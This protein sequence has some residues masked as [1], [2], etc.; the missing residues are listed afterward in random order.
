MLHADSAVRRTQQ[1]AGSQPQAGQACR[2]YCTLHSG[3][4]FR[5]A[6]GSNLGSTFS[7]SEACSSEKAKK[8]QNKSC[9]GLWGGGDV[10]GEPGPLS[11]TP[12][13]IPQTHTGSWG[14]P[15]HLSA[16]SPTGPQWVIG[17]E[18]L[19]R[20]DSSPNLTHSLFLLHSDA[21]SQ[22][23]AH[24]GPI[25]HFL[26]PCLSLHS[27]MRRGHT[28]DHLHPSTQPRPLAAAAGSEQQ[29]HITDL[30]RDTAGSSKH[31]CWL[32]RGAG[33]QD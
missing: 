16:C 8:N 12:S 5:A 32:R 17:P 9:E 19:L 1:D 15:P 29:N 7:M 25:L 11:F 18:I 6:L 27:P 21:D 13:S 4:S 31:Y 22:Q 2:P 30:A 10:R 28:R 20:A 14:G 23:R 3:A 26:R 24:P 33:P